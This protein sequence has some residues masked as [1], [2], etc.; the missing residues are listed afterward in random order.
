MKRLFVAF[1]FGVLFFTVGVFAASSGSC[2]I[3]SDTEIVIYGDTGTGGVG[4]LSKSWIGHFMS[5]WQ[6]YDSKVKYVFIDRNDVKNDC[7]LLLYPNVKLYVQP[8]GNAYYQQKALGNTG[9]ENI[10][11]YINNNGAYLGICAGAF[12]AANDYY[13]QGNYYDWPDLLKRYPTVEGS[14]TNIAD[15]DANP[16]YAPT[17]TSSGPKTF[18]MIYYGGPTV[19]WRDTPSLSV[20]EKKLNFDSIS[21][22]L[23]ASIKNGKMLLMSVHA[24]AYENDG[25]SGLTSEE[26][27][28]NYKWLANAIND[29]AGTS[30]FVPAYSEQIP[31]QCSDEI[32]NDNDGLMDYPL[33]LGCSS[34]SDNDENDSISNPGI[35][36]SDDFESG[37]LMGWTLTRVSGANN[38]VVATSNPFQGTRY[39]ESKPQSTIDPASIMERG[40]STSGRQGITFSY[41][42]RL[43]GL[44]AADEFKVKWFDGSSWNILEQTLGSS[45]N[46][47]GY[48][49]KNFNLPVLAN[50]N[51]ALK[52]KFECTAGAVSEFC[53]VD[54]VVVSSI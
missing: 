16:G 51:P 24:E 11:N 13:W 53:R 34:L 8:G 3:K 52:I 39:V 7:N 28:E 37:S 49:L 27:I 32:D 36:F 5:W 38:W 6:G 43:V 26:R 23:P 47:A 30:Y 15:Y 21:N 33:D 41:T 42:R 1:I 46:D 4:A 10:L 48:V 44:D 40:I 31:M 2:P 29:A 18:N 20:G 54:N 17:Q 19:G 14:I 35:L 25:I 50:N 12:Y 45:V 22:N 9:K